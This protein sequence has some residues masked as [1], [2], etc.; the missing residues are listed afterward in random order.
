MA[1]ETLMRRIR[2]SLGREPQLAT[3]PSDARRVRLA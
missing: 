3:A 2:T 1:M